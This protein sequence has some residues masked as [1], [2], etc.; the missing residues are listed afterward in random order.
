MIKI[1]NVSLGQP[2]KVVLVVMGNSRSLGSAKK[3][4]IDILEARVDLFGKNKLLRL[5]EE[6]KA[7]RRWG[8]PVIGTVRS[9]KEGGKLKIA[10]RRRVELYKDILPYVNAL[11]IELSST[12][13]LPLVAGQV[14]SARKVLILSHH[15]FSQTPS[16]STLLKITHQAKRL[17]ADMIK[18][19]TFVRSEKDI[20]RLLS[21]TYQNRGQSLVTMAMGRLG[22]FSRILLPAAGSLLAYTSDQPFAGQLSPEILTR[23][24]A[25]INPNRV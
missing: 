6:M 22:G 16:R 9:K 23:A 2:P 12:S 19:A 17:S 3:R 7:I 21:F 1:G 25:V 8:L 13:I 20:L 15:N 10:D 18:I 4:G 5:R 24:L 11:D 14:R